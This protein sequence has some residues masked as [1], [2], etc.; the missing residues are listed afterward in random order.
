VKQQIGNETVIHY[1]NFSKKPK[2]KYFMFDFASYNV[3]FA[4][5]WEWVC[6]WASDVLFPKTTTWMLC[7]KHS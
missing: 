1:T 4:C 7:S 2:C 5:S 3:H 6:G